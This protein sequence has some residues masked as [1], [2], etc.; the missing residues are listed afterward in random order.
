MARVAAPAHV[1]AV[2]D[3]DTRVVDQVC[4]VRIVRRAFSHERV[5]FVG[6]ALWLQDADTVRLMFSRYTSIEAEAMYLG[7]SNNCSDKSC[8]ASTTCLS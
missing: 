1:D 3:V 8:A 4:R 5:A 7:G 2:R 6:Q